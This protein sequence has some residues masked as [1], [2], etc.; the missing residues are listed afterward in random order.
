MEPL[1]T[2][3]ELSPDQ[4]SYR[5][6]LA[7]AQVKATD[8]D[9]AV[10]TLGAQ[11]PAA[12]PAELR[13][14]FSQLLARAASESRSSA[15]ASA[16]LKRALAADPGSKPLWLALARQAQRSG[17]SEG[18]FSALLKA[19]EL[20]PADVETGR[21][22][23]QAAFSLA[24]ASDDAERRSWYEQSSR[25]A[26]QLVTA[27]PS[28]EHR[29]LAGEALMGAGDYAAARQMFEQALPSAGSDA[30]PEALPLYYL[31]SCE[32]ALGE[33]ENAL[34]HLQASLSGS[35][36]PGLQQRIF[37]AQGSALR[38]LERFE[39]AAEAYRQAGDED[40]AAEMASLVKIRDDN[41]QWDAEKARCEA[42]HREIEQLRE[43]N[44]DLEGTE[45]W[46]KLIRDT[47]RRSRPTARPISKPRIPA[48]LASGLPGKRR[49]RG[50]HLH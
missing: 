49:R 26:R 46:R 48:R 45:A 2:A 19:H 43:D 21:Q 30:A 40:K 34:G 29:L 27:E 32:L 38:H 18:V 44:N 23:V 24:Q 7:Q 9:A 3:V 14:S 5:L 8:P 11:D 6:A 33:A 42:K 36:D 4:T 41:R 1:A 10:A 13:A 37:V 20:E 16:A 25:V 47:Q 35:S 28:S 22:A 50:R 15:A 39:E 12:V 17:Q 31:A